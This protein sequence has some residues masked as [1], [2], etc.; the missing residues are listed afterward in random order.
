MKD[1]CDLFYGWIKGLLINWED[2][3]SNI[4]DPDRG[5]LIQELELEY[6]IFSKGVENPPEFNEIS[7]K[8]ILEILLDV[9]CSLLVG[10]N[11]SKYPEAV[12]EINWSVSGAHVVVGADLLNRGFTVE[13]LS[14]TYMPRYS[15]GKT[16]SDTMQQRARFFGYK[17]EYFDLC[18]IYLPLSSITEY[19]EYV[20]DEEYIREFLKEKSLSELAQILPQTNLMN[21]TRPNILS[22]SVIK[23]KMEGEKSFVYYDAKYSLANNKILEV[24]SKKY[25]YDLYKDYKTGFRNHGFTAI[26]IDEAISLFQSLKFS[27]IGDTFRKVATIEYLRI[28]KYKETD[29]CNLFRMDF[30]TPIG[31]ERTRSIKSINKPFRLKELFSGRSNKGEKVYPGD[32]KICIDDSLSIQ[33]YKVQL[34]GLPNG[35]SK[36]FWTL[37]LIYPPHFERNFITTG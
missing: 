19:Q 23:S 3:L 15:K 5:S 2:T 34:D 32:S 18:R 25:S 29:H 20:D 35:N 22:S 30:E 31:E 6:N 8:D 36:L 21:A 33:I 7:S 1:D 37:G 11:K 28:L 10:K 14:F 24:F 12:Q 9:S 16:I 26:S 17:K 4:D 27:E 13:G